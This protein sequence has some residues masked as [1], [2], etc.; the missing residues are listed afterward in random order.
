[1]ATAAEVITNA[2]YRLEEDP[3]SP[4]FW[5]RA[6][7]LILLNEGYIEFVLG[8]GYKQ[9]Q[10]N[11]TPIGSKMQALPENC[12]GL[13]G[14]QWQ[15]KPIEKTTIEGFD[16]SNRRWDYLNG[17]LS[18]WAPCGVDRWFMNATPQQAFTVNLIT[19]DQPA[20]LAEGDTIG[21]EDEFIK[22]LEDYLFSCARFKEGGGEFRQAQESYDDF[23]AKAGM[24]E[25]KTFSE[26]FTL[27]NRDPSADTG[28]GYSTLDR[29]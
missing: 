18:Q 9:S 16:E 29:S 25:T 6:E 20:A 10:S 14:V 11:Y 4:I 21:L 23:S 13:I 27:W 1:M 22:G 24:R 19:L 17:Y 26:M 5:S 2:L 15:S 7:L 12:M 28:G 3:V 8:S